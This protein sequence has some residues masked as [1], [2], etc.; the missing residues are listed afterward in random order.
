MNISNIST[1]FNKYT[2]TCPLEALQPIS[3]ELEAIPETPAQVRENI[4]IEQMEPS[5]V[6]TAEIA[7]SIATQQLAATEVTPIADAPAAVVATANEVT[8]AVEQAIIEQALTTQQPVEITATG[9]TS[10]IS[11]PAVAEPVLSEQPAPVVDS[12]VNNIIAATDNVVTA[13][14]QVLSEQVPPVFVD[15]V[16]DQLVDGLKKP[17]PISQDKWEANLPNPPA[18]STTEP[19]SNNST[20]WVQKT[21]DS[22]T[23]DNVKDALSSWASTAQSKAADLY[24]KATNNAVTEKLSSGYE[25]VRTSGPVQTIATNPYV[26]KASSTISPALPYAGAVA[27]SLIATS[28]FVQLLKP[29]TSK[30]QAIGKLGLGALI[31][32]YSYNSSGESSSAVWNTAVVTVIATLAK[33]IWSDSRKA[34]ADAAAKPA[35]APQ[36]N[37]PNN[38]APVQI[39]S[40]IGTI[41][42]SKN[43]EENG[44]VVVISRN[45]DPRNWT[46]RGVSLS[47]KF[48]TPSSVVSKVSISASN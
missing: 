45:W 10:D 37:V 48:T 12:P 15:G 30:L 24:E 14:G 27:G 3:S 46:Y 1:I 31:T 38:Q 43:Q 19:A 33:T 4:A 44:N 11:A 42:I 6:T 40:P 13:A 16:S 29:N 18:P 7:D 41:T 26:E 28:G 23:L 17:L 21:Y 47:S 2:E 9:P 39:R 35:P 32:R 20:S 34:P 36:T 8:V 25:W 22:M 5:V